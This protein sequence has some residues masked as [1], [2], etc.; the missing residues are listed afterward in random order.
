MPISP[1]SLTMTGVEKAEVE[2][3]RRID[4]TLGYRDNRRARIERGEAGFECLPRG[5]L[6][7]IGLGEQ[8]AICHR[9]LLH[10]FGLPVERAGAVDRIDRR[11]DTVEHVAR[12]DYRLGHQGMQDRRWVG[13]T[14]GLNRDASEE[15][16][17]ALDP[18]DEEVG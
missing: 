4:D 8:Q 7:E 12:R 16:D 15:R 17:L 5:S 10:R 9:R 6:G 2:Q 18:V 14:G 1:N 3:Q 13:E 11:D